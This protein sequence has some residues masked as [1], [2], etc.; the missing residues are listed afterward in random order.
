[1]FFG[2]TLRANHFLNTCCLPAY[3]LMVLGSLYLNNMEPYLTAQSDQGL[4]CLLDC[5]CF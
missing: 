3:L 2:E 1:M 5:H 4:H